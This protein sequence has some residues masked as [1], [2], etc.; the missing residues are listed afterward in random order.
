MQI[1]HVLMQI[2]SLGDA[3]CPHL[4]PFCLFS[5]RGLWRAQISASGGV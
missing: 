3:V 4:L 2:I 1:R 5:P